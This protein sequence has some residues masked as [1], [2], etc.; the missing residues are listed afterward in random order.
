M[1]K[2]Q[3]E[4]ETRLMITEEQY[5]FILF[6][7]MNIQPN[8]HFLQITNHYFDTDELNLT[9]D[10]RMT[11]RVRIINDCKS[12]LTLKI[13]GED[14]DEEVTDGLSPK[15]QELLLEQNIFPYG[16]VRNRLML[17]PYPLNKYHRFA[18]LFNRRLEVE[19]E[20]HTLVI[21]KNTYND[22]VDYNIEIESSIGIVHAKELLTEYAN[23]F[24][25][26]LSKEKYIGKARRA[27]TAA[28]KKL[29]ND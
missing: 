26:T 28:L 16:Q 25:L 7:Y 27:I 19:F 2:T 13:K 11:L 12:E 10:Q 3:K 6:Y 20:D 23:K 17:L 22:E 8:Q 4:Y 18:S 24:N 5:F 29:N 14:G 21:D 15:E 9:K 1:I